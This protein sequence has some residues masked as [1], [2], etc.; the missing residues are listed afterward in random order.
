[1]LMRLPLWP[2]QVTFELSSVLYHSGEA[3]DG[4]HNM[5]YVR[6]LD[7]RWYH[8]DDHHRRLVRAGGSQLANLI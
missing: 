5:A 3:R 8:M 1:M 6:A 7:G 4:G 2:T